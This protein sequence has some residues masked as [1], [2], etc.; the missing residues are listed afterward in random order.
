MF[1]FAGIFLFLAAPAAALSRRD[2]ARAR[3]GTAKYHNIAA[4]LADG[5]YPLN[6][7][8][9]FEGCHWEK[10]SLLDGLVVPETPEDLIY[11]PL[12][13]GEWRLVAVEYIVPTDLSPKEPEGFVGIEDLW[14]FE[15]EGEGFWEMTAWIWLDNPDGMFA[16]QN[17]RLP[18]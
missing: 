10:S 1:I 16:S 17:P 15:S 3:A 18:E 7:C 8:M 12:P 9:P 4:A 13:N 11:K 6:F 5:Y 14:R 2:I